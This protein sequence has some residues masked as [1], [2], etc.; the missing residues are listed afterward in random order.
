MALADR[1]GSLPGGPSLTAFR[2]TLSVDGGGL[3]AGM[4]RRPA[5]QASAARAPGAQV[6][7]WRARAVLGRL[8]PAGTVHFS[9][10]WSPPRW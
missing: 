7:P 4:A 5:A 6:R 9:F 1:A 8:R 3:L 10:V 2:D